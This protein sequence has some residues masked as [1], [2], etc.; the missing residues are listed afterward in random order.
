MAKSTLIGFSPIGEN[1]ETKFAV[2]NF[3]KGKISEEELL[4]VKGKVRDQIFQTQKGK[5]DLICSNNFTF[6]DFMLDHALFLNQAPK[7]FEDGYKKDKTRTYF[8]IAKKLD[9]TR[10]FNTSYYFV[11]PEIQKDLVIDL[12]AATEEFAYYKSKFSAIT[13]PIYVGPVTFVNLS[14]NLTN[15][16][17][18]QLVRDVAEQYNLL[19]KKL[20]SEGCNYV[21]IDEPYLIS[22]QE[23]IPLLKEALDII[24]KGTKKIKIIL[25]FYFSDNPKIFEELLKLPADI[26]VWD[27]VEGKNI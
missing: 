19:I 14:K 26:L 11:V 23:L 16:D 2:E 27:F 20:E 7:K 3:I 8:K 13:K 6:Y 17:N 18:D 9:M 15:K 4:A 5:I 12:N 25:Q 22:K 1:R 24:K 10:F 21:Q